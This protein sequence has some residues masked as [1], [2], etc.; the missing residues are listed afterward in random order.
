M[1]PKVIHYCWFGNNPLPP[2]AIKCINSWKRY[3]PDYEIRRWDES[4]FDYNAIPYTRDA[5][6]EKRFAFVSDYARFWILFHHGG[7][8]FDTDVEII[9]PMDDIIAEGSFMGCEADAIC[10]MKYIKVAPGLCLGSEPNDPIYATLLK[11]YATL[12]FYLPDGSLNLR[13]IVEYTTE[14]LKKFGLQEKTGIQKV[15]NITIYPS[16]YFNP[17]HY[18]T[19]RKHITANTRS[20]HYGASSWS[21]SNVRTKWKKRIRK[22]VPEWLLLL[23]NRLKNR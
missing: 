2:L 15:G 11:E 22:M 18:V 8:Y 20:I 13:T 17:V 12:S 14:M 3:L 16:D 10:G 4:N 21:D 9:R 6:R 23:F 19:K 7:L 5:Y 1:I